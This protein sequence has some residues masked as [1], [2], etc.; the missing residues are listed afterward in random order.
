VYVDAAVEGRTVGTALLATVDAR[1]E[2]VAPPWREGDDWKGWTWSEY[3]DR[4]ARVA[5]GLREPGVERGQRVLL[6]M[7]NR[8]EFH[9]ADMA[10]LLLGA[11]PVSVS[12]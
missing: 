6:M 1:G 4:A 10:C 8:A 9:V 2:A 5:S 3:A 12:R 11:T 7:P